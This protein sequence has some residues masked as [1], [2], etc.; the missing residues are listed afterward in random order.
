MTIERKCREI[1]KINNVNPD[2]DAPDEFQTVPG[3]QK[4]K[5]GK[6]KQWQL[7]ISTK[8]TK[9]K[10]RGDKFAIERAESRKT[11]QRIISETENKMTKNNKQE[12]VRVVPRNQS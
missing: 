3:F 12:P 8:A 4:N 7:W 6:V 11:L 1:C 5:D 2:A 10:P 9:R